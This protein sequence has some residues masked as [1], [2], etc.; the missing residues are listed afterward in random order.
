MKP[1]LPPWL[2]PSLAGVQLASLV[3]LEVCAPLR[4]A[5]ESKPRRDARNLAIAL[6]AALPVALLETPIALRVAAWTTRRRLGLVA[7]LPL[8]AGVR[9]ALA[10][11]A[12][13]YTLYHW[14]RLTHRVPALWRF[15]AVHHADR[16]MD[17]MT[18]LRF[19]FGEMA[20]SVP[21]RTAQIVIIGTSPRTYALWQLL[22]TLSI[23]FHHADVKLPAAFERALAWFIVTPRLHGIHHAATEA[24]A[25]KNWSSGLSLWDR[26]HGT[27]ESDV[28]QAVIEIGLPAYRRDRDVGLGAMLALPFGRRVDAWV[29]RPR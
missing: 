1:P 22:T 5:T 26:L 15:H 12:L 14:H 4:L 6:A 23:Q 20:L 24:L 16:D 18:A 28:P 11:A 21:W 9:A 19:H 10:V 25:K 7:R 17:A 3:L 2:L 8:P 29:A 27:Y 13:D